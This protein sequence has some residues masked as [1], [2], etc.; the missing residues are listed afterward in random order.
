MTGSVVPGLPRDCF[1]SG[2]TPNISIPAL[3][4]VS[5]EEKR[6]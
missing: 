3:A 5:K 6:A 1:Q 2:L 4:G